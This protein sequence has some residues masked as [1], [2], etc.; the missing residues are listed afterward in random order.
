MIVAMS[1]NSSMEIAVSSDG[2]YTWEKKILPVKTYW[3]KIRYNS[4]E[5]KFFCIANNYLYSTSD[6]ETFD[7]ITD[8]TVY[9]L[10]DCV[11]D[12]NIAYWRGIPAT[13][14]CCEDRGL[15]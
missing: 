1:G 15:L 5:R 10:Q 2:G 9:S 8:S 6:F 12:S 13:C 7:L 14:I 4:A 3:L 11:F